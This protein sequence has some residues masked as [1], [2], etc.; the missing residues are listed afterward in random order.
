[1]SKYHFTSEDRRAAKE[2]DLADFLRARGEQL[3]KSGTEYEWDDAGRKVSIRGNRWYSFYDQDGGDPISFVEKYF[4]I[5]FQESMAV[6]LSRSDGVLQKSSPQIRN[7]ELIL[8][9]RHDNMR[10]VF[11]YL[12]YQ[13]G[14]DRNVVYTFAHKKMLYESAQ[15]HNVV[16]V[17]YDKDGVPRHAQLRST[18]ASSGF[19]WNVPGSNAAYSFHFNGSSENVFLFEAPIDLMSFVTM[20]PD[21]WQT[22]SYAAACSVTDHV[23]ERMLKEN[24]NLHEVFICFDNDRAGQD[25]TGRIWQ[26]LLNKGIHAQILV[27][28]HKDWNEDLLQLR[29]EASG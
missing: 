23:L 22:H 11:A 9:P 6:L 1:M 4:G 20:H 3:R 10:R 21:R 7:G 25:A 12:L 8:P 27:P 17:G 16:F 29:K 18:S 24:E 26:K 14:L 13:R 2:V 5:G 19:R 15:Y 28:V